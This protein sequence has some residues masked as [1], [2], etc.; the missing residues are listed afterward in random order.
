MHLQVGDLQLLTESRHFIELA[1]SSDNALAER[2]NSVAAT[3]I[4]A[5][6]RVDDKSHLNHVEG[7]AASLKGAMVVI[8]GQMLGSIDKVGN[9]KTTETAGLTGRQ[10]VTHHEQLERFVIQIVRGDRGIGVAPFRDEIDICGLASCLVFL[11]GRDEL[12]VGVLDN[13]N[14]GV[15]LA[16]EDSRNRSLPRSVDHHLGA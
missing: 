11:G 16:C 4:V 10:G 15:L 9:L 1:G 3:S 8:D 7:A 5:E 6:K 12:A 2:I 14:V 13:D